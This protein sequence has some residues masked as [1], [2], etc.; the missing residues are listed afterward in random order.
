MKQEIW[1]VVDGFNGCYRVSNLGNF[2][3]C[4]NKG[5]HKADGIWRKKKANKRKNGYYVVSL[6]K[7]GK[8]SLLYLHRLVAQAFCENPNGYNEIDHIDSNKEN[9]FA[10]NLRWVTHKENMHNPHAIKE[11]DRLA[12][13][14]GTSISQYTLDGIYIRTFY[15]LRQIKR[16]IPNINRV[17]VRL[18]AD[19]KIKSVC[20]YIWKYTKN[21]I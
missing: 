9:N 14:N 1:K 20:G 21:N 2:E 4:I 5:N 15:S 13:N 6:T 3:S 7:D 12:K 18:C 19:G 16:E 17:R 10:E 8:T 11:R